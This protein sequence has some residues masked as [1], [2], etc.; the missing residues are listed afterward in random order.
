MGTHVVI[1]AGGIGRA[2]ARAL[3]AADQQVVVLSRSGPH[4]LPEGAEGRAVDI[5]DARALDAAV[6]GADSIVNAANPTRYWVWAQEWPVMAAALLDAAHRSGAGLVTVSNLYG[7]GRVDA[8]MTEDS[9][10][11]PNGTKGEIR[12]QMWRDA[13]RAHEEGRCRTTELRASDYFGP[14]ASAGASVLNTYVIGPAAAGRKISM[15]IGGLDVPHSWTYLGDIGALA[16]KLAMGGGWGRPWH[17][18]TAPARTVRQVATDVIALGAAP[19]PKI[20]ALPRFVV[21]AGGLFSPMLR[22]LWETRHQF[23][24]PFV[25]D[26]T[27]AQAAFG[28]VPTPW[29]TQLQETVTWLA[30]HPAPQG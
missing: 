7:Y 23:E 13:L 17:V 22:E 15:P 26:S 8:P 5:T 19:A 27:A 11:R 30:A 2:T 25:L 1:G 14:E 28:L 3:L 20:S 12:A 21:S 18:P 9:P 16:A 10:L 6:A 29:E 4:D 24:R